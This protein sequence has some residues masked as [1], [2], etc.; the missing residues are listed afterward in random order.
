MFSSEASESR[1]GGGSF[2]SFIPVV[3]QLLGS[4]P[5]LLPH[6]LGCGSLGTSLA[7]VF[8]TL[9]V[10]LTPTMR[11]PDKGPCFLPLLSSRL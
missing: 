7:Q 8:Q 3:E 9:T 1:G 5:E 2:S 10:S 6:L 4:L 11:S